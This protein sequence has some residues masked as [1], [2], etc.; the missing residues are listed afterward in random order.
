MFNYKYSIPVK[1]LLRYVVLD[2][3]AI[4]ICSYKGCY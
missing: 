1:E 2:N 3:N 4:G